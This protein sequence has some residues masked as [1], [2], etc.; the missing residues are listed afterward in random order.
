MQ[1]IDNTL[2]PIYFLLHGWGG[3]T[4]SLSSL[5][6]ILKQNDF[7][8]FNLEYPGFGDLKNIDKP[9]SMQDYGVWL[10]KQVQQRV[11]D[12]NYVLVGHSFG[13]KMVLEVLSQRI[14]SPKYSVLINASGMKPKNT[15]KKSLLKILSKTGKILPTR[16]I[17]KI[18][19]KL[20][21]RE[22]DY[23]K[24][25][26][27]MQETFKIII[28]EHYDSKLGNINNKVLI[29]WGKEDR[30]TP[31]EMAYKLKNDIQGSKLYVLNEKGHSLP[32]KFPEE[33]FTIL[34]SEIK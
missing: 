14:L 23:V 26:G 28:N 32:L 2:K 13:G 31:V 24:L 7:E 25:S 3:T 11:S 19:Y 18:F 33:I 30:V 6:K 15:F 9:Y 16:S 17:R 34:S 8:V 20:I 5:E 22:S 4:K 21:V 1:K 27:N 12:E 29:I 10:K